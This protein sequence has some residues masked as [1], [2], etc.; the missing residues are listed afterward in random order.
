MKGPVA[1][2]GAT[3]QLAMDFVCACGPSFAPGFLLY[4]RNPDKTARFQAENGLDFPSYPLAEFGQ[5]ACGAIIHFIGVGD[6]ARAREMGQAIFDATHDSDK[7]ALAYLDRNPQTTYVFLSSGAV[8]G[9]D[10][11]QPVDETT[12]ARVPINDLPPSSYYSVA[13]LYAESRHRAMPAN[14]IIDVRIFNY[15]SRTLPRGV[16]YLVM[17]M[18]NAV[19]SSSVFTTDDQEIMRDFLHVSDF[20]ALVKACLGAPPGT[21]MAVD[22]YS[23]API[24]K[25]ELVELFATHFGMRHAIVSSVDAVNATGRKPYYYSLNK[26]AG[27]LGYVP[28]Y[29]SATAVLEE[30]RAILRGS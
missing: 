15:I 14:T 22:A 10:Y 4:A 23:K 7:Q 28:R 26:R 24:T 27:V 17:D 21:N 25:R 8:Y 9:T 29:D 30:A 12:Q 16:R 13:K 2:L 18:I 11:A 3:S 1:I 5:H 19:A 20:C 6:P